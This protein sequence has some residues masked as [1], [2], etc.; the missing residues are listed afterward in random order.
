M[1]LAWAILVTLCLAFTFGA[2]AALVVGC[3]VN[4]GEGGKAH[5]KVEDVT[6]KVTRPASAPIIGD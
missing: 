4:F 3:A 5:V 2:V 6:T 1:K